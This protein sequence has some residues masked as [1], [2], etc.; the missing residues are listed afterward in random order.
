MTQKIKCGWQGSG[1]GFK[2]MPL[3]GYYPTSWS[4]GRDVIIYGSGLVKDSNTDHTVR[5]ADYSNPH[6]RQALG[7]PANSNHSGFPMTDTGLI[8]FS[9]S[10]VALTAIA[11]IAL[12]R[13]DKNGS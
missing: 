9:L 5:N 8:I 4:D 2:G 10:L 1:F 3:N 13:S 12:R 7:G 6:I 11:I